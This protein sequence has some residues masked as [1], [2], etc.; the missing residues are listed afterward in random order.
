[1]NKCNQPTFREIEVM[2]TDKIDHYKRK[3]GL[4]K[5]IFRFRIL[6]FFLFKTVVVI[7][8]FLFSNY[9]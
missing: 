2:S 3:C 8:S 4:V 9:S 1:M 7:T 6:P 5:L